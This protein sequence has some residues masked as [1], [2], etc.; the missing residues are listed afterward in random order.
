MDELD[1]TGYWGGIVAGELAAVLEQVGIG[2]HETDID[3]DGD[4]VVAFVSLADAA[5]FLTL[6]VDGSGAVGSLYDRATSC[7]VTLAAASENLNEDEFRAAMNGSW[8]WFIHPHMTGRRVDWDI[9][10]HIPPADA[11]AVTATLNALRN[12]GAL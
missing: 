11:S 10:A 2:I 8:T 6:A 7:C 5:A 12:G 4:V 9:R 3:R 1:D